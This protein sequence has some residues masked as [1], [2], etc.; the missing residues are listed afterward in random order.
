MRKSFA[1]V[2]RGDHHPDEPAF[3]EGPNNPE[4]LHVRC[5][6][7]ARPRCRGR[8]CP[9]EFAL[10]ADDPD[11]PVGTFVH[12]VLHAIP[13]GVAE[14]GEGTVGA[15]AAQG[16]SN[17]SGRGEPMPA[18][19]PGANRY[20]SVSKLPE[21]D[22]ASGDVNT[23]AD[24]DFMSQNALKRWLENRFR[25]YRVVE[26]R[27]GSYGLVLVM[28]ADALEVS[29]RRF[30]V[31]TFR[32]E[33]AESSDLDAEE[34]FRRELRLWLSLPP[35]PNVVPALGL[36]VVRPPDSGL[37][38]SVPLVRMPY[39]DSSLAEWTQEGSDAGPADRLLA[40]AYACAGLMWLY[41][42]GV[43]GHGHLKPANILLRDLKQDFHLDAEGVPSTRYPWAARVSDLGWADIWKEYRKDLV[44]RAWSPY[45]A[46]ERF[47]GSFA[48]VASDTFA[49]AVIAVELLQG[50]HPA[51]ANTAL[52]AGKWGRSRWKRWALAGGRD[53]SGVKPMALRDV[54][55][56]ALDP[57]P[58]N[59]P[60]PAAVLNGL[61]EALQEHALSI[62]GLLEYHRQQAAGWSSVAL[63]PW[64]AEEMARL[65]AHRWSS[66][67]TISSSRSPPGAVRPISGA[68]PC[69]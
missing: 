26:P 49:L 67:S 44:D 31:K 35:H 10:I 64:V 12:W 20:N 33:K 14:L 40:L 63:G 69:G 1:T 34:L 55:H 30:A 23:S 61:E 16:L 62:K 8:G 24:R 68:L 6:E 66:R 18:A 2:R 13:A 42:N 25:S 17:L 53:L 22:Q 57:E 50:R 37:P 15:D 21:P 65:G 43:E 9:R 36:E 48:A 56:A 27:T 29:P 3:E 58:R 38:T 45:R 46:P 19:G 54:L 4:A 39:C 51:G 41:E 28:E 5:F 7:R 59:R 11:A 32:P 47:Q 52:L 60:E